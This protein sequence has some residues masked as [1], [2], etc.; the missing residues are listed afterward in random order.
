MKKTVIWL[1]NYLEEFFMVISLILMTVFMGIQVFSRYVLGSA[2][3][4]SEEITRYL[5]VWS[6]FLSVSYCT[7]KCISI[8]SNSLCQFSHEEGRHFLNWSTIPLN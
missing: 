3:S 1:D 8:R 6:G 4:W 5:F 7:K 2:P